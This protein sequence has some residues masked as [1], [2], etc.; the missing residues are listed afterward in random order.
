LEEHQVGAKTLGTPVSR[1]KTPF[2]VVMKRDKGTVIVS[3]E[4]PKRKGYIEMKL[5]KTAGKWQV[6][7]WQVTGEPSGRGYSY[8][9]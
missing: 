5:S 8:S 3:A 9:Y 4:G 7:D 6:I 2:S 1:S